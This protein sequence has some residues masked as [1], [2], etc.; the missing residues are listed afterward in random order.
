MESNGS[1]QL[2]DYHSD[3]SSTV[4]S[5]QDLLRASSALAARI[6]FALVARE[7]SEEPAVVAVVA[8]AGIALPV[9]QHAVVRAGCAFLMV[10]PVLPLARRRHMLDDARATLV[11]L[12]ASSAWEDADALP[13]IRLDVPLQPAPHDENAV[14]DDDSP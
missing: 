5:W 14:H 13:L 11:I 3:G 9:C 12:A 1:P 6:R 2:I 7:P 4:W 8:D 10:D